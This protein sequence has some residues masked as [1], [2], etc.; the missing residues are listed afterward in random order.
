MDWMLGSQV[1]VDVKQA[2]SNY[3]MHSQLN[4]LAFRVINVINGQFYLF[5]LHSTYNTIGVIELSW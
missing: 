2:M 4:N 1:I 3:Q 5:V